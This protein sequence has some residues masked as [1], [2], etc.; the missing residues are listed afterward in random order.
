[1]TVAT[2]HAVGW[3]GAGPRRSGASIALARQL[4]RTPRSRASSARFSRLPGATPDKRC[5]VRARSRRAQSGMTKIFLIAGAEHA[6]PRCFRLLAVE[7]GHEV[8]AHRTR[9]AVQ[10]GRRCAPPGDARWSP[11]ASTATRSLAAVADAEPDVIVHQMTALTGVTFADFEHELATTNRLRTEGIDILLETGVRVIAQSYG[12][13]RYDGPGPLHTED[14]R[15]EEPAPSMVSDGRR[16]PPPGVRR[17][18]R[19]RHR[20]A[21]RHLQ[22]ARD[23]VRVPAADADLR[24]RL[25]RV[26]VHPRRRRRRGDPG[27]DRARPARRLQHRRRPAHGRRRMAARARRTAASAARRRP[28]SFAYMHTRIQGLSNEKAKR[29][30]GWSPRHTSV[31]NGRG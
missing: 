31:L 28:E 19:R 6:R 23:R 5:H 10:A 11:T 17:H 12:Q 4:A 13:W 18:R 7:N 26:V 9:Y 1:M 16:G 27:R 8:V 25:R 2:T 29:E 21:L 3:S 15:I 20:A 22:R 24:R 30:L 14:E